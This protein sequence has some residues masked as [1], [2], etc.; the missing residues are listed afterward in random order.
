[1]KPPWSRLTFA[2]LPRDPG[3]ADGERTALAPSVEEARVPQVQPVGRR[4]ARLVAALLLVLAPVAIVASIFLSRFVSGHATIP[5]GADTPQYLWRIRVV[6]ETGLEGLAEDPRGPVSNPD[7]PGYPV[8]AAL[9]KAVA[10]VSAF[11]LSYVAPAVMAALVGLAAAALAREA[12]GEPSWG[13][14]AYVILVG[15]SVNVA[16]TANGYIDNL[17]VDALLLAAAL[18]A[19][20]SADGRPAVGAA[21]FLIAGATAVHWIFVVFFTGLLIVSAAVFLPESIRLRRE[22]AGLLSTPSGRLV[23]IVA[24]AVPAGLATLGLAPGWRGPPSELAHSGQ[25]AKLARQVP[26]YRFGWMGPA[27]AAGVGALAVSLRTPR[28]RTL[29]FLAVWALTPLAAVVLL[30]AGITLPSQRILGFAL[31]IPILGAAAFVGLARIAAVKLGAVGRA[32]GALVTLAG[33]AGGSFLAQ[34]AWYSRQ[35]MMSSK[36]LDKVA[37][38]ARFVATTP[39]DRPVVFVVFKPGLQDL[40]VGPAVR[41]IRALAP[42]DRA[43]DIFVYPGDPERVA[44]GLPGL[45]PGDA[46]LRAAL[47]SRRVRAQPNPPTDAIVAVLSTYHRHFSKMAR[48]H[49]EWVVQPGLAVVRGPRPN[50]ELGRLEP[51]VLPSDEVLVARTAST[52]G[53]LALVGIGWAL[54]LLPF[55]GPALAGAAPTFGIAALVLGGLVADRLGFSLTGWSGIA[56]AMGATG[57]GWLV[58]LRK[59]RAPATRVRSR[60]RSRG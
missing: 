26:W 41:R 29:G 31:A 39:Q 21:I 33:L 10:G 16:I 20:L 9:L 42:P 7:R 17:I 50:G 44:A 40:G 47:V 23:L 13:F 28:L 55:R 60:E 53:V 12:L 43:P 6:Q 48:E 11:E 14:P 2:G 54:A 52:L 36:A 19:L 58:L 57:A 22:G 18:A 25:T 46:E 34:Q 38:A 15:A 56:V 51:P 32:A 24:A 3:T 59:R 8:L 4:A 27:A 49:P 37:L 45:G 35:E 30:W 5:I 1:M